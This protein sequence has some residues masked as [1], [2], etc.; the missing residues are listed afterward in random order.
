MA[1]LVKHLT[2]DLGSGQDLIFHEFE[3]RIGLRADSEEPAWDFRSPSCSDPPQLSLSRNKQIN[4]K[5]S[6][7][8]EY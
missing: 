3:P 8:D 6:L 2:L 1:Q 5:K 7:K 4:I